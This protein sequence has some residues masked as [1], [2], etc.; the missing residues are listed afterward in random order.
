MGILIKQHM[1]HIRFSEQQVAEIDSKIA[2]LFSQF[3]TYITTIPGI[4]PTL[5]AT[6]FSE[7]G[8]ISRFDSA[9]KFA[10]FAGIDPTVTQS[11]E[12][13]GTHNHMSKRG[14]PY[15]RRA[16]W[17]ASTAAATFDPHMKAFFQK[18]RAEGK[19]YMNAIGH[20]TRKMTNIIFAVLR[21][22]KPY[23]NPDEL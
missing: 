5:G 11:G 12:F 8:D 3:D 21:D 18:K 10:A 1:E 15:L 13:V 4:G 7:I 22:N 16:I 19:P 20:V 6:I 9:A 14:S 23:Y 2:E 17:Q